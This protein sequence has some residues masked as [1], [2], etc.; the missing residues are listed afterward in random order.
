MN[1]GIVI[2]CPEKYELICLNNISMLRNKYECFL[3]IEIWEIG[4]EITKETKKHMRK[5]N[6]IFKN[7]NDYCVNPQHWKGFQVKAIALY[8]SSF[9]ESILVDADVSFYKNPEIIFSDKNYIRTGSYF[10]KDL[11]K[12]KFS[13]L[14]YENDDKFSSLKFFNSRKSFIKRLLP[15]KTEFFPNEFIY[16]YDEKE[17]RHEVKEALQESGVVYINKNI[18]KNSLYYI[19]KLNDDHNETY[20]YFWGDKE[21]FWLG[22]VLANKEY[23]FNSSSGFFENESLTHYYNGEKFWKQK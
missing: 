12:W 8:Y 15:N 18:H 9:D 5:Y 1:R 3:P 17:P 10:F 20:K 16:L 14:S 13:N 4:E 11:E 2:A 21:T 22:C 7:V 19:L 23:Y 6:V